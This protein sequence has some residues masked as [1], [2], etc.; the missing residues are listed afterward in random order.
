LDYLM[1]SRKVRMSDQFPTWAI[2]HSQKLANELAEITL[3]EKEEAILID[4]LAGGHVVYLSFSPPKEVI[5]LLGGT[6]KIAVTM[7]SWPQRVKSFFMAASEFIKRRANQDKDGLIDNLEKFF[8]SEKK[9]EPLAVY[10]ATVTTH[11]IEK[12]SKQFTPSP[13][14]LAALYDLFFRMQDEQLG[15]L[16]ENVLDPQGTKASN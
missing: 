2:R 10:L 8:K 14:V 7:L 4:C 9:F 16:S 1:Y 5:V 6:N 12:E 13:F 3:N 15:W 11:F